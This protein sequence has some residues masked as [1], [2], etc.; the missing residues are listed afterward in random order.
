[1]KAKLSGLGGMKMWLLA[2][3]EKAAIAVVGVLALLLVYKSFIGREVLPP[4]LQADQLRQQIELA[5]SDVMNF[6]WDRAIAEHPA[7]VRQVQP[8]AET[9]DRMVDVDAYRSRSSRIGWNAPLVP[10]TVLRTDPVLLEAQDVEA[11]GGSGL[12]AF[13]NDEIRKARILEERAKQSRQELKQEQQQERQQREEERGG[14]RGRRGNQRDEFGLGAVD[15]EHPNRRPVVGQVGSSGI[16]LRGDEEVV[17]AYW[18]MVVA[19]VPIKDQISAFEDVFAN[20]RGY[21]QTADF[22]SYLGFYVERAEV[23]PGQEL[24]WSRVR[25][26]NGK[27]QGGGEVV[28]NYVSN[29]ILEGRVA[30][31]GTVEK[32]GA[33]TDWAA[34]YP[35]VVDLRYLEGSGLLAF[36]LPPLVGRDWGR[37]LVASHSE[38]PLASDAV[39]MEEEKQPTAEAAEPAD[40]EDDGEM[41]RGTAPNPSQGIGARG[42]SSF[43]YGGYPGMRGMEGEMR[44]MPYSAGRGGYGREGG[45]EGYGSSVRG[46]MGADMMPPVSDWLLRFFDFSVEPGKKYKY[47]V[48]MVLQDPNQSSGQRVVFMNTLDPSVSDRIKAE[49]AARRRPPPV[50]YRLTEPSK[51]S[52]TVSI[53]LAGTVRVASADAANER[54]SNSEPDIM[55]L[56]ES[57]GADDKGKAVQAAKEAEFRRGSVANMTKDAEILVEQG[58]F[59][60]LEKNFKFRTGITIVD[61]RG[62]E[63]LTRDSET[64]ARVLLMD[65]AGQLFVQKESD[66][67]D[68]IERHRAIF[69]EPDKDSPYGAPGGRGG[70][71][72][73]RGMEMMEF[74][75]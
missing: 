74:G 28:G 35:E 71:P 12:L 41:F 2:H 43:G 23:R 29:E 72:G 50:P 60:D 73:P 56:V 16:P 64:E 61:I 70:Y 68:A 22:P 27:G 38:I 8:L 44:E 67:A 66:D 59:I 30:T 11:Y 46:A 15:P 18:A 65:P 47:R 21:D 48:R 32:K 17:T 5:R 24:D 1:M 39:E 51:P 45:Y 37:D 20:A 63:R 53:P 19:K 7:E 31:D 69:A 62:G 10:P 26:C 3:G 4:N 33:T 49:K 42:R 52:R 58:R 36:P 13:T 25:V 34:R 9:G 55:L 75:R 57:F 6:K 40:D 54:S 14:R